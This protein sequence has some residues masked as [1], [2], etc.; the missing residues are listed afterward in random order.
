MS[1]S[2]P[3]RMSRVTLVALLAFAAAI[4]TI[5]C[6]YRGESEALR[7]WR[8]LE[9]RSVEVATAFLDAVA[10]GDSAGVEA[11]ASDSLVAWLRQEGTP[12]ELLAMSRAAREFGTNPPRAYVHGAGATITFNYQFGERV[13]H[14]G[15][16][17]GIDL[18]RLVVTDFSTMIRIE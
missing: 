3:V 5:V 4:P 8:G 6:L 13:Q 12:P 9:M 14:G 11:M 1:E 17:V 10:T 2:H 16:D 15:L 7:Y 18:D